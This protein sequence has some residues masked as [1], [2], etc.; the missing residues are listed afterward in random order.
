MTIPSR[1]HV[2]AGVL[3]R[4]SSYL[5]QERPAGKSLAGYWEFPGGKVEPGESAWAALVREL[6]EELDIHASRGEPLIQ[7]SHTYP[8]RTVFL[9]VWRVTDWRREPR[10]QE[11]QKLGWF[12][13]PA[14]RDMPL[15][16]ADGP[17]LQAMA[18]P[19]TLFV[20]PPVG[21]DT[22][23]FLDRLMATVNRHR[24]EMCI[25][26]QP[27]LSTA[28]Y[29]GLA[30]RVQDALSSTGCE[31]VLHG[32]LNARK[33]VLRALHL[34][35]LHLPARDLSE[36]NH[37]PDWLQLSASCHGREELDAAVKLG[38][39]FALLGS[40]RATSSHPGGSVL[41]W[42]TFRELVANT[43]MPVYAIG[44]MRKEDE[45]RSRLEGAQGVAGISEWWS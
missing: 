44:G 20:T 10:A 24:L 15:L 13:R 26:R 1:L 34:S 25:L 17:I 35:R 16:P 28:Q 29:A 36:R 45:V 33:D 22:N 4:D 40:V 19:H 14:M 39:G 12:S 8:Q 2:V 43:N 32:A 18:L 38:A 31:L 9:D 37:R 23:A 27:Q 41:G 11:G 21:D 7:L 30:E 6:G 3:E 5:I 42:H